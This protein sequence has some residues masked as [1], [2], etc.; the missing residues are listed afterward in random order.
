MPCTPVQLLPRAGE[1]GSLFSPFSWVPFWLFSPLTLSGY[2]HVGHEPHDPVDLM[3]TAICDDGTRLTPIVFT[4][5]QKL[6]RD[7][8]AVHNLDMKIIPWDGYPQESTRMVLICLDY[9]MGVRDPQ[10]RLQKGDHV[11]WDSAPSHSNREVVAELEQRSISSS[12]IPGVV[13]HFLLPN[14]NNFHGE[15]KGRWRYFIRNG[16][17]WSIKKKFVDMNRAYY[18]VPSSTIQKHFKRTMI[19]HGPE[20]EFTDA[21]LQ[22]LLSEGRL[23]S[24]AN[25]RQTLQLLESH[26]PT[27]QRFV[28]FFDS[29]NGAAG[30]PQH[31][32]ALGPLELD[33][34]YWN[35]FARPPPPP[36]E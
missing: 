1:T 11:V 29:A 27:Y 10:R 28:T 9:W 32:V 35:T 14:D 7:F 20:C 15:Y 5:Q 6:R 21:K 16:E 18:L 23:G 17:P 24:S 8:E 13:H 2:V 12:V 4:Q 34:E 31:P 26:I 25:S 33:G 3:A 36:R 30:S 22:K 19:G